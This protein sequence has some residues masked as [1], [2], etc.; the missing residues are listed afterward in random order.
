MASVGSLHHS[1]CSQLDPSDDDDSFY[2]GEADS[3]SSTLHKLLVL[4]EPAGPVVDAIDGQQQAS[5]AED[6]SE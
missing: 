2:S 3:S 5:A 1:S 6:S 4:C